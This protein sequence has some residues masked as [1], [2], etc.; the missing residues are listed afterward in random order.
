MVAS[1]LPF[2]L[3]GAGR[4]PRGQAVHS[5]EGLIGSAAGDHL[6]GGFERSVL[7]TARGR[8]LAVAL[9]A[10]GTG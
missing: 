2:L 7:L 4:W 3:G 8:P 10:F 6:Y 5:T 1:T 9:K